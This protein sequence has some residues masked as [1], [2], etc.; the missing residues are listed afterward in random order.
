[1][2]VLATFP[3]TFG[4]PFVPTSGQIVNTYPAGPNCT[5][6]GALGSTDARWN[7]TTLDN[8]NPHDPWVG[9]VTRANTVK[10]N[11]PPTVGVPL[12]VPLPAPTDDDVAAH[13]RAGLDPSTALRVLGTR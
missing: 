4:F 7:C 11:E 1:M 2:A 9:A 13:D 10:L 6:P 3:A 8:P 12:I 5:D